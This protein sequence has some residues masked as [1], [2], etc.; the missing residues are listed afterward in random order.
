MKVSEIAYLVADKFNRSDDEEFVKGQMKAIWGAF[1]LLV[2]QTIQRH[3]YQQRLE[4]SI[5][6]ELTL[7]DTYSYLCDAPG[8]KILVSKNEIPETVRLDHQAP[9][10]VRNI[11]GQTPYEYTTVEGWE[12]QKHRQFKDNYRKY[13]YINNRI[14][15]PLLNAAQIHQRYVNVTGIF[16]DI[17]GAVASCDS[18]KPSTEYNIPDDIAIRIIEQ[19]VRQNQPT[20]QLGN[21]ERETELDR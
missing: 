8:C 10:K 14:I 20:I 6:I 19:L 21:E 12:F 9:Y 2:R 1:S 15:I 17:V 11:N 13:F 18:C 3:G 7:D 4:Y 5:D 16:T